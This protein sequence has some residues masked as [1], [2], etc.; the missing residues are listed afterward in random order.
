MSPL[1]LK[2]LVNHAIGGDVT[3][4]YFQ[5]TTERLRAEAGAGA[6]GRGSQFTTLPP[7]KRC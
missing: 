7:G 6:E 2:A 1:A 3:A 4:G 5:M